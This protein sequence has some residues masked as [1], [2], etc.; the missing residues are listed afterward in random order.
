[1]R[2]II[3]FERIYEGDNG[4]EVKELDWRLKGQALPMHS[5]PVAMVNDGEIMQW[6]AQ[7]FNR[8][9]VLEIA[10]RESGIEGVW[11]G[12]HFLPHNK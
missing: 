11:A 9:A 4:E 8:V 1:M 6:E 10:V 12:S 3:V 7:E 5:C 2:N